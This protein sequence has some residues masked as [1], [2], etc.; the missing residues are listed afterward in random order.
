MPFL[1]SLALA[2]SAALARPDPLD[3]QAAVPPARHVSSFRHPRPAADTP[4]GDWKQANDAVLKA[5][6][7]KAYA[8]EAAASEPKR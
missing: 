1:L 8:R 4:P 5:G 3:A 7:W 2:G 6:G